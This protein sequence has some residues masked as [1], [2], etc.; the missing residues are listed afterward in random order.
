MLQ[1]DHR[2]LIKDAKEEYRM[3]GYV[4]CPVLNNE[5][6]YF[7][8]KGF[9]H[10]IFRDGKFRPKRDQL[11]RLSLLKDSI[12]I[13]RNNKEYNKDRGEDFWSLSKSINNKLVTVV[14]LKLPNSDKKIFLSVFDK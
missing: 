2:K 3:I 14:V 8:N 11:R 4:E 13:I 10:L 7:T 5:K 1:D 9:N 12:D 6:I